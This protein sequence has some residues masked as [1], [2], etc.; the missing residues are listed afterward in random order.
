LAQAPLASIEKSLDNVLNSLLQKNSGSEGS[1]ETPN[2]QAQQT[3][4]KLQSKS[5]ALLIEKLLQLQEKAALLEKQVLTQLQNFSSDQSR[6]T[7]T[8]LDTAS[9]E[10][11][12][13]T[14]SLSFSFS[15]SFFVSFFLSSLTVWN[16][17][18]ITTFLFLFLLLDKR[19]IRNFR[20]QTPF[21][22]KFFNFETISWKST[23]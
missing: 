6:V 17:Q 3:E 14:L 15:F 19:S 18:L 1:N 16:V 22:S 12:V 8:V 11:R 10:T 13:A 21:F 4:T 23:T 5:F 9:A 20:D 7:N 2:S